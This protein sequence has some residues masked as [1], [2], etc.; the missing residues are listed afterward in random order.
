MT[1]GDPV[2]DRINTFWSSIAPHYE[3]HPGNVPA[4]ATA[5]YAAWVDALRD[6]LPPAPADVLDIGTGTGFVAL[7]A[8]GLGH[9][10]TGIDLSESMLQEAREEARR[11][12]LRVSFEQRDAVAPGLAAGSLDAVV[13]RHFLWTLRQPETAFRNWRELLRPGGR[14][15]A[16]DGHW[17]PPSE[18]PSDAEETGLDAEQ[19]GFFDRHYTSE[20]RS[21]L[22]LMSAVDTGPVVATL[23]RAGLT[24]VQVSFLA[25]VHSLAEDPPSP[26][27]WYV[28]VARR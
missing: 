7:I 18:S 9:R 23:E 12:G 19:T 3:A 27:P 10:V 21:A 2:Q 20:T 11:R 28:V 4:P 5:E 16:I 22:P 1:D 15:V 13:C 8:A 14:L 26:S 6:L 25:G 17:F 24:D